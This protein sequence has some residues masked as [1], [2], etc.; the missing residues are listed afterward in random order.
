MLYDYNP[1]ALKEEFNNDY[2]GKPIGY[3]H[4]GSRYD[5]VSEFMYPVMPL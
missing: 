5:L 3:K 1:I 2:L 4:Q